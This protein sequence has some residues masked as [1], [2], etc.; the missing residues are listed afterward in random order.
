MK[1]PRQISHL[2]LLLILLFGQWPTDAATRRPARAKHGM[3]AST[4]EMAS[5]VGVEILKKGGNAV[6][7]A[8]AVGLA[9]AVVYPVAGNLGG[10]G[11]MLIRRADGRT[12]MLD[13]REMAPARAHREMYLDEHGNVI[14]EAST[15]GYRAVGVPGT[16]AGFA[17]ALEK[18]G[19]L[20]WAGVAAPAEKL[21]REG[22]VVRDSLTRS[23]KGYS[24]LLSRFPDSNRIFLRD[25]HPY[26][27]GEILRQPELAVTLRRLIERGPREF[28]E[29]ETAR[30]IADDMT[31]NGGLMT[32]EDLKTYRVVERQPSRTTYRGYEII[33]APPPSSGGVA[34]IEM[35]HM[36]EPY[37]LAS[38][39]H[40]S[41]EYVHLLVEVMRRAF[42]DR[43]EFLGDPDFSRI[44]V[45]GLISRAYAEKHR[46]TIDLKR[47]TPSAEIGHG[48]PLAYE[49]EQTT[50]YTVVDAAGN[51]VSNTYTLNGG[52]GSG[53]VARGTGI[54]LNSEMDDFSSKPGV[55][56]QF[57]L[58]QGEANAVG[59]QKRPLSAM[60]PTI[61]L[62][63]GRAVFAV[64]SPGGPTIINTVL[65]VI[66]NVIDFKMN[67][68]QA[69]DMPRV[70]H[71]WLPDEI[72]YE[73]FGLSRD[74]VEALK[75]RGHKF[76]DTP[77]FIGDAHGIMIEPETGI[78]LGA[79]DARLDGRAVGY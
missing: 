70:H 30:M 46:E 69:F 38:L 61:V 67:I 8:V 22:F 66:L 73:P 11:F 24:S 16:V 40:N 62:K 78:R 58:I 33:T 25:G 44:P 64:G 7:A 21:A 39:G 75:Q 74:T 28:Y 5:Q 50:H 13:Y 19:S 49:S 2:L 45:A 34:L 56:N 59:P 65:Q 27:E 63:D 41:S 55:P 35:L 60:T 14:P 53:V 18:F 3:V 32:L 23:L 36:L 37:D 10:G 17:M 71:Q 15:V 57:G 31:K 4:S 6:D 47:A 52:Y 26:Q 12:T 76:R 43:A 48:N 29:G 42:A 79:S 9:L 77:R 72:T 20:S 54:L 68:Q 1:H 51:I